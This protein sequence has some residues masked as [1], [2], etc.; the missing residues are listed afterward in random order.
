MAGR[1]QWDSGVERLLWIAMHKCPQLTVA[2]IGSG[3]SPEAL[4]YEKLPFAMLLRYCGLNGPYAAIGVI[5]DAG[6]IKF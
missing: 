4:E 1:T 2:K 3:R 6:R 5:R